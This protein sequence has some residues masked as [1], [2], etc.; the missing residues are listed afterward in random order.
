[1][2]S[3]FTVPI[4]YEHQLTGTYLLHEIFNSLKLDARQRN[5]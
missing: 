3:N 2:E 4:Y 1:M 5:G